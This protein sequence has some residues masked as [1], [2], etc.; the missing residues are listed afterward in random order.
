MQRIPESTK[1]LQHFSSP[2]QSPSADGFREEGNIFEYYSISQPWVCLNSDQVLCQCSPATHKIGFSHEAYLNLLGPR[3]SSCFKAYGVYAIFQEHE[4]MTLQ[5]IQ[6]CI[7]APTRAHM[8]D[9]PSLWTFSPYWH[10]MQRALLL[11][12]SIVTCI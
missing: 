10:G 3:Y 11:H 12:I 8:R 2:I 5:A 1:M 7:C 4:P 6:V 9:S